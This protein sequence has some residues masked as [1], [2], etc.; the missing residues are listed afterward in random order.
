MAGRDTRL[1]AD[2]LVVSFAEKQG[3]VA[4][5]LPV[6][7]RLERLL[8]QSRLAGERTSRKELVAA[9]VALA[10]PT[11]A[12]LGK[13]LRRYRTARVRDILPVAADENV[14]PFIRQGPGPRP[15]RR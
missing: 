5:P 4:W 7:V 14:V 12:Q 11:D 3:A 13:M 10:N 2:E 8:E 1:D 6:E 9:L 15:S